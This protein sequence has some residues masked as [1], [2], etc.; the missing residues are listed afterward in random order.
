MAGSQTDVTE[1]RRVQDDK[2]LIQMTVGGVTLDPVTKTPVVLLRD[3]DV[4]QLIHGNA[5]SLG[6]LLRFFHQ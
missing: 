5:F 3:G 4:D 1:W 2:D 6:D